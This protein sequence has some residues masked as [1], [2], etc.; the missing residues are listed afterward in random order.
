[1]QPFHIAIAVKDLDSTRKFYGE[2]LGLSEG[3]STDKWIDWN[4]F[5]HQL[6]THVKPDEV[7]EAAKNQVDGKNVPVRH[8][9]LILA[10]QNWHDLA[11][12]LKASEG[13][14]EI[15]FIIAII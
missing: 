15:K 2:V 3:R 10:W 14:K 6:S 1:M 7:S 8:F 11:D 9:G 12:R 4:F 5:S 13:R